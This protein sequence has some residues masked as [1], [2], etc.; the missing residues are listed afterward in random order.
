MPSVLVT[1]VGGNVGQGVLRVLR[2]LPHSLRLVGT[3][4][5]AA[6][7][8]NHLCDETYEVPPAWDAGYV[9]MMVRICEAEAVSAVIPTTDHE[10]HQLALA[11]AQ[12]PAL[13][14][15]PAETC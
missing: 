11:R 9:P 12:L 6:S 7:G 3:N 4:T 2:T 8:G 1:G 13:A 5:T 10:A 15:S 14:A